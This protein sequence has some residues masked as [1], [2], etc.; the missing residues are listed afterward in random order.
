MASMRPLTPRLATS[1]LGS[2]PASPPVGAAAA[3]IMT[4]PA[5]MAEF[6]VS[7]VVHDS[8][9]LC[10]AAMYDLTGYAKAVRLYT[11]ARHSVCVCEAVLGR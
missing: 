9:L 3:R 4:E 5:D 11:V 8:Q 6:A 1:R 10:P 2:N 7:D